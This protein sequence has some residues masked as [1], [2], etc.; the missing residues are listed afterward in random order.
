MGRGRHRKKGSI[1]APSRTPSGELS[2]SNLE[3]AKEAQ[4]AVDDA[5]KVV[6]LT[7]PHRIKSVDRKSHWNESA[8]GAFLLPL[9]AGEPDVIPLLFRAAE[10]YWK[11]HNRWQKIKCAHAAYWEKPEQ[12]SQH[13]PDCG[14][15]EEIDALER[16]RV[17][18]LDVR[19][20][21]MNLAMAQRTREGFIAVRNAI[22]FDIRI[23]KD[24]HLVAR[25]A[26]YELAEQFGLPLPKP[27]MRA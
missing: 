5:A 25:H 10:L 9:L 2:R 8:I 17:R 19:L 3:R 1:A 12:E 23:R 7:Q 11:I 24:Q 14:T 16:K 13:E 22:L 21:K 6:V 26:L 18:A 4:E 15:K 27:N 20:G